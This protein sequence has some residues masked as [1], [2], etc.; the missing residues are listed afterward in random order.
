M[1][2]TVKS[3]YSLHGKV[4]KQIAW[5]LHISGSVLSFLI[6][7]LFLFRISQSMLVDDFKLRLGMHEHVNV[8]RWTGVS[9]RVTSQCS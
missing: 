9:S 1:V 8:V 2:E 4:A 3:L 6:F 7:P 5:L